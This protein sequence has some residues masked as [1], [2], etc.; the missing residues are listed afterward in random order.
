[1]FAITRSFA[2]PLAPL[3]RGVAWSLK[4]CLVGIALAINSLALVAVRFRLLRLSSDTLEDARESCQSAGNG[5]GRAWPVRYERRAFRALS[6]GFEAAAQAAR[7]RELVRGH[8]TERAVR[9]LQNNRPWNDAP[10]LRDDR[11]GELSLAHERTRD[12]TA[13]GHVVLDF[14]LMMGGFGVLVLLV[15]L[16]A[17]FASAQ[18]Q[19]FDTQMGAL[20]SGLG[21]IAGT[22]ALLHFVLRRP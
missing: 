7:V 16:T 19:T 13:E 9:L 22:A 12:H 15:L 4:R 10:D 11:P 14:V 2:T 8:G 21:A 1:M 5:G 17:T 20:C 18:P 3:W 6:S